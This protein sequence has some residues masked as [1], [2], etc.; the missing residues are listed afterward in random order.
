ML[1][2]SVH[3]IHTDHRWLADRDACVFLF[4]PGK[5]LFGRDS[6]G[7][8]GFCC[9]FSCVSIRG[10]A[11]QHSFSFSISISLPFKLTELRCCRESVVRTV[12][13]CL[14]NTTARKLWQARALAVCLFLL[15]LYTETQRSKPSNSEQL[16]LYS[17]RV[18]LLHNQALAYNK[19]LRM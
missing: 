17:D 1:F 7:V 8:V 15:R 11:Q 18:E 6:L 14:T 5:L 13:C 12:L 9:F 10:H 4:A 16:P 3:S 2:S 19:C